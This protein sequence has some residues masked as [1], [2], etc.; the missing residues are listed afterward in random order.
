MIQSPTSWNFEKFS[1]RL[2]RGGSCFLPKTL[3]SPSSV[4][5]VS[6]DERPESQQQE[7]SAETCSEPNK[8]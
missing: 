8:Q 1:T 3:S 5:S 7:I 4:K 6:G 2:S